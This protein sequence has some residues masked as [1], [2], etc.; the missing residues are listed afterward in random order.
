MSTYLKRLR[1][2]VKN[3]MERTS[4][5]PL[6]SEE[7]QQSSLVKVNQDIC[8]SQSSNAADADMSTK[9]SSQRK[10]NPLTDSYS[11]IHDY[12]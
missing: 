6:L 8:Q 10:F 1:F 7:F 9:I 5:K 12:E 3:A 2:Y 11:G 4:N